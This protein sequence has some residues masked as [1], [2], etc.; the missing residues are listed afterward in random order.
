MD[1]SYFSSSFMMTFLLLPSPMT[2]RVLPQ[3]K[4]SMHQ[5]AYMGRK[6]LYTGY[7][8]NAFEHA[9][10]T[11]KPSKVDLREKVDNH[12]TDEHELAPE[13]EDDSL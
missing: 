13:Q 1:S 9:E 5:K 8:Q 3:E 7:L 6:K 12:P 2:R 4:S 11:Q 10:M